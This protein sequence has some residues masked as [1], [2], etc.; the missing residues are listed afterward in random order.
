MLGTEF[1]YNTF[2]FFFTSMTPKWCCFLISES[3]STGDDIPR[4]IDNSSDDSLTMI[5]REYDKLVILKFF[6]IN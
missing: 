4:A 3:N 1:E 5:W 6:K 2:I